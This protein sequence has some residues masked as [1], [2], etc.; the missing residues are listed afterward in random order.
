MDN[1]KFVE[2]MTQAIVRTIYIDTDIVKELPAWREVQ[3]K[4]LNG[5]DLVLIYDI[6]PISKH[7]LP[8]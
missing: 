2:S 5:C 7:S 6:I 1:Y 4:V 3:Q 8:S